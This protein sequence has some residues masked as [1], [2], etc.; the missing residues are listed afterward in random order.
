MPRKG[1]LQR[2][3]FF[4]KS[5]KMKPGKLCDCIANLLII[6]KNPHPTRHLSVL[7]VC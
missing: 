1:K 5:K 4:K 7:N 2:Y 3:T 6:Y